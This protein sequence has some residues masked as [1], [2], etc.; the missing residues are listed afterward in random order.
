MEL[1]SLESPAALLKLAID[2]NRSCLEALLTKH[3]GYLK[4]LSRSQLD[5]RLARRVSIADLVQDT[6]LEAFRDFRSFTGTTPAEFTGWLRMILIHNADREVERHIKTAKRDLRREQPL[7]DSVYRMNE[8]NC[9]LS[10]L[11]VDANRGPASEAEHQDLLVQMANAI[12]RL[13]DDYRDVIILR[14]LESL[15]FGEIAKRMERSPGAARMLWMR[16]IGNLREEME[17]QVDD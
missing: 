11:L 5:S 14:H 6:L 12:E 15:N 3:A 10:G 17:S 2:G 16:A 13:P 7:A 1:T 8:S 4:V 9:R